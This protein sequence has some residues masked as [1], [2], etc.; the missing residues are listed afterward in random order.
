[1]DYHRRYSIF[2][3]MEAPAK[4]SPH[5]PRA[6]GVHEASSI[7]AFHNR[8]PSGTFISLLSRIHGIDFLRL[9]IWLF[10]PMA[11]SIGMSTYHVPLPSLKVMAPQI[12]FFFV[13]EDFFHYIGQSHNL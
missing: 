3:A 6:V 12:A 9:Q 1:M 7:L 13:F 11:E 4:Q 2:P 8:A 5:P 10:H